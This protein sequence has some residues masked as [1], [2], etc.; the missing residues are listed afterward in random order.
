[1]NRVRTKIKNLF[2]FLNTLKFH[3]LK[4]QLKHVM[5]GLDP[6]IH[7]ASELYGLPGQAHGCPV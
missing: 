7:A 4:Q 3:V 6:G 1:M 2:Q 5:L